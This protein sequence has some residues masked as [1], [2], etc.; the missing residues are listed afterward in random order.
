MVVEEGGGPR[1]GLSARRTPSG[2]HVDLQQPGHE[3]AITLASSCPLSSPPPPPRS[4]VCL[5]QQTI[6][7]G[8]WNILYQMN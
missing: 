4:Y 3:H 7:F 6:T 1:A 5:F 8:I 2:T